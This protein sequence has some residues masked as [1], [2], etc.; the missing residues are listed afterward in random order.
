M[1]YWKALLPA[2][3]LLAGC[4]EQLVIDDR[5]QARSQDSRVQYIVLHY[6]SSGFERSF[7]V[8]TE[9]DVSSHYLISDHD[10][11]IYRLVDETQRAWHA[12]DSSWQGRTWLNASSIGIEMVND[13][14]VDEPHCRRWQ[15]WDQRQIDALIVLLRDIQQRHG[16]GPDA[17]IGHSDI[18][19]QRKVD[20]GPL[21]PWQQLVAAGVA[22]G[23]DTQRVRVMYNW[24][25]GRV[26]AVSWFQAALAEYGYQVPQSGELDGPTRNVIAAFQMRFRQSNYAGQP[27]SETASLLAALAPKQASSLISAVAPRWYTPVE[28]PSAPPSGEP[29]PPCSAHP[30]AG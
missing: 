12:G 23:P 5:Y 28:N 30:P 13:G 8:L 11:V 16:L 22:R 19:P 17:V 2:L 4:T 10:P 9:Q 25:D 27:D 1:S 20:P 3:V 26:P 6:T 24:L 18:A 7:K 29:L 21:F 15:A 14:Y